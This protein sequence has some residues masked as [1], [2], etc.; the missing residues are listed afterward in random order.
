MGQVGQG[1]AEPALA[2]RLVGQQGVEVLRQ[3][4]QFPRVGAVQA[5]LGASLHGGYFRGRPPQGAEP[6]AQGDQEGGQQDQGHSPQPGEK[7]DPKAGQFLLVGPQVLRHA[8]GVVR[9]CRPDGPGDAKTLH[10]KGATLHVL[11]H[12]E[13]AHSRAKP[14]LEGDVLA[15]GREG[16][17]HR[18]TLG[19]GDLGVETGPQQ[20]EARLRQVARQGQA[21][22]VH[23]RRGHQEVDL[24]QQALLAGRAGTGL[25]SLLQGQTRKRDKDE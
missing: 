11:G 12:V 21:I 6:P 8:E 17:P 19:V 25:E 22:V 5:L 1:V 23:V 9:G 14:G 18:L 7:V 4:T 16:T 20:A 13:A 3:G 10:E 15:E 2:R 24:P